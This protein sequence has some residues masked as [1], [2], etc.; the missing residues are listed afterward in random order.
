MEKNSLRVQQNPFVRGLTQEVISSGDNA[1]LTLNMTREKP[2]TGSAILR[3][4][5]KDDANVYNNLQVYFLK[6]NQF[7]NGNYVYIPVPGDVLNFITDKD[8]NGIPDTTSEVT[9]EDVKYGYAYVTVNEVV[10]HYYVDKNN[11]IPDVEWFVRIGNGM[12]RYIYNRKTEMYD[13]Q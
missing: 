8:N 3:V 12:D 2:Q 6:Y 1:V 5:L 13:K 7:Y 11:V 9:I 10:Y 4:S